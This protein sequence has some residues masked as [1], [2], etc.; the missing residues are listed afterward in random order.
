MDTC[1]QLTSCTACAAIPHCGW[2]DSRQKC[3]SGTGL[4]PSAADVSCPAWF[5]YHCVTVT[6]G[7]GNDNL[8]LPGPVSPRIPVINCDSRCVNQAVMHRGDS[9]HVPGSHVWCD[10][11]HRACQNFHR[12][13]ESATDIRCSPSTN[14]VACH[15]HSENK[16][17][18]GFPPYYNKL[19][20]PTSNSVIGG[21]NGDDG[22]DDVV[23][24]GIIR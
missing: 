22:L 13:F 17:P 14:A 1:P 20:D 16:C 18:G 24:I 15:V 12:C 8:V 23:I 11:H 6:S 4:G 3:M 21:G 7:S 5:F 9:L 10:R 19:I 2:C